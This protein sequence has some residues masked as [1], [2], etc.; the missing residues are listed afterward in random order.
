MI[1]WIKLKLKMR[2]YPTIQ[3]TDV[4]RHFSVSGFAAAL[5]PSEPFDGTFYERWCS[6]MI[7]WLNAINCYHAAQGKP[8]LFTPEEERMFDVPITCFVES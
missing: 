6:K 3:K 5:K 1:F 8:K 7:L 2:I 4:S